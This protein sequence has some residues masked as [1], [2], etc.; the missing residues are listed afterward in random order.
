MNLFIGPPNHKLFI[1]ML[2]RDVDDKNLFDLETQMTGM[3]IDLSESFLKNNSDCISVDLRG[4][5]E[6]EWADTMESNPDINNFVYFKEPVNILILIHEDR[7]LFDKSI[8]I[9]E[10]Y[11]E[12]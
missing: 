1:S 2:G 4:V 7:N 5:V 10:T 12:R 11:A 9:T 8:H 3:I 6:A